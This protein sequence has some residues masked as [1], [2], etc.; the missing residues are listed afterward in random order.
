MARIGT[1]AA[2]AAMIAFS[3]YSVWT[4]YTSVNRSR[5]QQD[6]QATTVNLMTRVL[7][8]RDA[9]LELTNSLQLLTPAESVV[10][11][12]NEQSD[13][14]TL[15][16]FLVRYM[17]W[18]R[19]LLLIDCTAPLS[20]VTVPANSAVLLTDSERA[21]VPGAVQPITA[22]VALVEVTRAEAVTCS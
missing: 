16:Q 2:L 20:S 7:G 3:M 1:W 18:P 4:Q 15:L 22:K 13:N 6:P 19:Y 8:S 9:A 21:S 17:A 14:L 5:V 10:T 12:V 11:V